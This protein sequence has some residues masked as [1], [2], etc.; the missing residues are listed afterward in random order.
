MIRKVGTVEFKEEFQI[1]SRSE[2]N[3]QYG[4]IRTTVAYI[5]PV[6]AEYASDAWFLPVILVGN[7]AVWTGTPHQDPEQARKE[8]H[9]RLVDLMADL[10]KTSE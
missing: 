6:D 7:T 2:G 9:Y 1:T 10:L 5:Y 4:F 8:A 3:E